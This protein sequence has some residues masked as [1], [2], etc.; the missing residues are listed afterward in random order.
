LLIVTFAIKKK[1]EVAVTISTHIQRN[2]GGGGYA[3]FGKWYAFKVI[4]L[5]FQTIVM[6]V[7]KVSENGF[8]FFAYE[9]E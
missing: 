1:K 8:T 4:P 7:F 6:W 3:N 5:G 2:I 9:N